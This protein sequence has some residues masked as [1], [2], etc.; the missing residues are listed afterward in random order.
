MLILSD[1]FSDELVY[2]SA[3][4]DAHQNVISATKLDALSDMS[5][6]SFDVSD[7]LIREAL[8]TPRTRK[9]VRVATV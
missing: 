9:S 1:F 3:P 5:S 6:V 4:K 2:L 7:F 8:T